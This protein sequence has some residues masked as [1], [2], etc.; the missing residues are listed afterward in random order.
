[1]TVLL[2]PALSS[3][4]VSALILG[5]ITGVGVLPAA[6]TT[7]TVTLSNIT[8]TADDTSVSSG[9]TVT[10]YIGAGGAVI[11]P[12]SV[13]IQGTSYAVTTIGNFAFGQERG[14]SPGPPS[15]PSNPLTSITIPSSVITIEDSAFMGNQLTAV[16]IPTSVTSIG[17][18]AFASNDL[19][20]VT[21]PNSVTALGGGAFALN[22]LTTINIPN[23]VTSIGN[24]TFRG[25]QLTSV[26]IPDGVVSIGDSAFELNLLTSVRIPASVTTIGNWAFNQNDS[27][28]NVLFMGAPPTIAEASY[29]G[30]FREAAGKTIYYL[31]AYAE[32]FGSQWRGYDTAPAT[33]FTTTSTPAIVGTAKVGQTL[34][35]HV[36]QWFP[37][38]TALNY[39]WTAEG[40]DVVLGRGATYVPT[41]TDVGANLIA[42]VTGANEE[43][44]ASRVSSAATAAVVAGTFTAPPTPLIYGNKHVGKTLTVDVGDWPDDTAFSYAWKWSGTTTIVGTAS[45]YT[46]V[47]NDAGKK[48]TVT[49]TGTLPGYS[50]A[51]RTSAGTTAIVRGVFTLAPT[52]TITATGKTQVGETLTAVAGTWNAGATLTYTWKRSGSTAAISASTD[53]RYIPVLADIGKTLTVSVTATRNGFTTLTR[54]SAATVKVIG[55]MFATVVPTISGASDDM[56]TVGTT[57]TAV[58]GVWDPV[59]TFT[60]VWKR[61]T[62]GGVTTVISKATKSSYKAVA[63]DIGKFITVTVTGSK[64]LY[65]TTSVT[66]TSGVL[67]GNAT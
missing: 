41:A 23:R 67:I 61:T 56:A 63:A 6:A 21:I 3:V 58:T 43:N 53:G 55:S 34:T 49:V 13:L 29:T 46:P 54:T 51:L 65:A 32:D 5:A 47:A 33:P 24:S 39:R 60:Y 64:R 12:A 15:G 50:D 48:L 31:P 35:T 25:N 66:S 7:R 10:D 17:S 26:N 18:S 11:I 1:M 36:G 8:Y 40:S 22:D 20:A 38:L 27:L 16:N 19:K 44:V 28:S 2:K 37:A 45:R 4:F 59:P 14:D 9:A 42:T 57:L 52:P 62:A 30:S